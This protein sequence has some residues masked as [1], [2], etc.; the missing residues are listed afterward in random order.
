MSGINTGLCSGVF[1]C[2]HVGHIELLKKAR[3]M[4]DYLIVMISS[5]QIVKRIKGKDPVFPCDQRKK[6][7]EAIYEPKFLNCMYGFRPNKGCHK[8]I[9]SL[10]NHLKD[11][12][13]TRVVDADI[14]GFFDHMKHEWILKFLNYYSLKFGLLFFLY[15]FFYS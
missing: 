5:D 11:K 4:C 13:I 6:I 3:S 15:Q 1:D 8:A 2:L 9:K 7:L 10:Y 12:R 14:K